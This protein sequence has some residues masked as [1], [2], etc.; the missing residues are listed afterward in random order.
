MITK[1]GEWISTNCPG[2]EVIIKSNVFCPLVG[3]CTT[4]SNSRS[5]MSSTNFAPSDMLNE[6]PCLL[7]LSGQTISLKLKSPK[8]W[9]EGGLFPLCNVL[10]FSSWFL[11]N[12]S[13]SI[14]P[15]GGR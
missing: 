9:T 10:T 7:S 8:T 3:K 6:K 13:S 15:S 12:S 11:N 4:C 1:P 14:L 2:S 5:L